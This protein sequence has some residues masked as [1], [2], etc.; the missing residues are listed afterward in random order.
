M[1]QETIKYKEVIDLG[2][3]RSELED[4]VFVGQYGYGWFLMTKKLSKTL[5]LDWDCVNRTVT[6]IRNKKNNILSRLPI[7]NL[8][9][10]KIINTFFTDKHY[11]SNNN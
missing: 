11:D 9:H 1:I 6:L 4:D 5:Y 8:E 3:K 2:F 10:L 7:V